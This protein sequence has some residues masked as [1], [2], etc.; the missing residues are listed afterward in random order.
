VG[1]SY[2]SGFIFDILCLKEFSHHFISASK[3]L[4]ILREKQSN[5]KC[6]QNPTTQC[7]Q[8]KPLPDDADPDGQGRLVSSK[9]I[10]KSEIPIYVEK[11]LSFLCIFILCLI[12]TIYRE[13]SNEYGRSF[14]LLTIGSTEKSY[15]NIHGQILNVT[16]YMYLSTKKL[17]KYFFDVHTPQ[18]M[19]RMTTKVYVIW[20]LCLCTI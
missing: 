15:C 3:S 5:Y 11:L 16:D 17:V 2:F 13:L 6:T 9:L 1:R 12:P 19:L 4:L 7:T 8:C 20:I 10:K 18:Q 14:S